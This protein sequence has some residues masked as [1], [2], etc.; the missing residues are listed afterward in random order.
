MKCFGA[1]IV[2]KGDDAL[3]EMLEV[4]KDG[5]IVLVHHNLE[6]AFFTFFSTS[7]N[8]LPSAPAE[9]PSQL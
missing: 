1:V 6:F 5:L 7:S 4:D 8:V 2:A 3:W 9:V